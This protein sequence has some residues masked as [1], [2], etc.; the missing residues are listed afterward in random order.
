MEDTDAL[1][2]RAQAGD[3]AA[4]E[5]LVK[6]FQHMACGYAYAQLGDFH[7]AEDAA[8]EA[9]IDAHRLLADLRSP[10]AFPGWLRRILYKHCDRF[11]R[12]ARPASIPPEELE[13]ISAETE[14][15]AQRVERRDTYGQVQR[16][17][18]Q[19]SQAQRIVLTLFYLRQHSQREI[20]AF[21]E[22]PLTAVKKR[23]HDA[24]RQ[25]KE[26]MIDMVSDTLQDHMPDERFSRRVI[27]EL[28]DRPRPLQIEGHPVRAI[29]DQIQAALPAYEIVEG[30]EITDA[31]G[32]ATVPQE[33]DGYQAYHLNQQQ[34]LRT[35]MTNTTFQAIKGR[36]APVRLLAAGRCFRPDSE[37]QYH[38]KVFHQVDGLYI[39]GDADLDALK[40]TCGSILQAV[41]GPLEVRW[42]Q[43]DFGFVEA[44]TEFDVEIG[45]E[46]LEVGGGGL[47]KEQMLAQAG[48][49][50][51][52]VKG[53]AFGLGLERLAMLKFG[54]ED[55]RRLWRA[56]YI[57]DADPDRQR[58]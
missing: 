18:A 51:G 20:A 6:R 38:A 52:Q 31:Q 56:P 43:R 50:I 36:T 16:A 25:L 15:P 40:E 5:G 9:F 53:F 14:D 37:D 42:R 8:Q 30:K 35:Q 4:F 27:G 46:W 34:I 33:A 17:M 3:M 29:W 21:L 45:G 22:V 19:L 44:G 32:D 23:L 41:F 2:G 12:S 24:R 58:S 48:Y 54:I 28:L 1:V 11:T 26:R 47:L 10:A 13:R 55:I 57:P 7:L 49:E 39:G